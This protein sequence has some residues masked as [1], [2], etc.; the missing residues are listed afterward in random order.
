M[1]YSYLIGYHAAIKKKKLLSCNN[2]DNSQGRYSKR[3][4]TKKV[5]IVWFQPYSIL[6][7]RDRKQIFG[8]PGWSGRRDENL[9]KE[10]SGGGGRWYTC[11][12]LLTV[13]MVSGTIITRLRGEQGR[14]R[15][16]FLDYPSKS[17]HELSYMSLLSVASRNYSWPLSD[18]CLS[19]TASLKR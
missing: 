13:V 18:L 7:N 17:N 8:F 19:S 15:N 6:E 11:R 5:H 14:H 16:G 10:T 1:W 2:I 4:Q 9:H 12:F 3:I